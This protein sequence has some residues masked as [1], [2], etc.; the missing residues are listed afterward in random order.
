M[1]YL[2]RKKVNK[3]SSRKKFNKRAKKTKAANVHSRVMRGGIRL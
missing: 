3:K 2:N 1:A